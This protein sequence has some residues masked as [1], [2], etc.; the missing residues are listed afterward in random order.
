MDAA[1]ADEDARWM[2]G[3][4]QVHLLP[5]MPHEELKPGKKDNIEPPKFEEEV[6]DVPLPTDGRTDREWIDGIGC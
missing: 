6:D 1:V 3:P 5:L 4:V 2:A